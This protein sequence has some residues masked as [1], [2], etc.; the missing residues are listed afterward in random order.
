M[1]EPLPTEGK[2]IARALARIEA[3]LERIAHALEKEAGIL[4]TTD[5]E[6]PN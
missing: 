4:H 6:D 2:R 3:T 1:S 5:E